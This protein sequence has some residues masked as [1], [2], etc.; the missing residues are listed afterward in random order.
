MEEDIPMEMFLESITNLLNQLA[1]FGEKIID[2][3]VVKMVL[4]ALPEIYEYYV[5]SILSQQLMRTLDEFIAKL[6]HEETKKEFHGKKH[7]DI[8]A[9]WV[10]FYK[11]STK[12]KQLHGGETQ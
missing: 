6:L 5:Q 4:N 2:D 8:K 9:L 11:M 3:V 10:K 12:K 7:K 1:S